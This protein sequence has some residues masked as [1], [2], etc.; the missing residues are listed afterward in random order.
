MILR[1][2]FFIAVIGALFIFVAD[3]NSNSRTIDSDSKETLILSAVVS[4]M[5]SMHLQPQTIDDELSSRLFEKYL[6]NIDSGRR[7]LTREDITSLDMYRDKLDDEIANQELTFFDKS[8]E[9]LEAG[10]ERA[11]TIYPDILEKPFDFTRKEYTE[12]DPDKKDFAKDHK[13]LVEYWRQALKYETLI[14]LNDKLEAQDLVEEEKKTVEELEVEARNAVRKSTDEWFNR[15]GKLRRSDRYGT[16]INTL[17]NF[18]DPHSSYYNPKEKEDFDMMMSNTLEGIGARLSADGELTKISSIVP[19]GPADGIKTLKVNDKI[20]SVM[21]GD[22]ETPVNVIG[23]RVD[24]VASLI[25]GKKGTRVTLNVRHEDGEIEDI[26]I[27]RDKIIL[28]EGWAK[29]ALLE[30]EGS[31]AKVGYIEVPSFYADI[32]DRS[33]SSCTRDVA[34]AIDNLKADGA[35]GIILDLRS[36]RGGYLYEVLD[37]TGLFIDEGPIVQVKGRRGRSETHKDPNGGVYYD[38]PLVVMVNSFSASA[39]EILAGALQDYDRAVIVGSKATYGKGTVQGIYDLDRIVRAHDD[40][41]PLGEVKITTQKY[42]RVNGSSVQ[43]KGVAPDI[44]LPDRY[45]FLEV[46]ERENENPLEWSSVEPVSYVQDVWQAGN[47]DY[48]TQASSARLKGHPTWELVLKDAERTKDRR[49]KEQYTLNLEEY[50]A[51]RKS[52]REESKVFK[53]MYQP[54]ETFVVESTNADL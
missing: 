40:M 33:S 22:E 34:R 27:V 15:M 5:N 1:S 47:L 46:G 54:I 38:G 23:M 53:D 32:R 2:S 26:T 39:S 19:G 44:V 18:F 17:T 13:E 45:Q 51:E 48:V 14:R 6:D 37:M 21:Q 12:F 41:K 20:L 3:W 29:S 42:Y 4:F 11:S 36:N 31:D 10:I 30:I 49:D 52:L 16:Y 8:I 50:R 25:R 24:D 35:E 28:E 43:L 9:L 7:F